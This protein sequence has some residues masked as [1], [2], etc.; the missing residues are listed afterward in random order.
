MR[1]PDKEYLPAGHLPYPNKMRSFLLVLSLT[2]QSCLTKENVEFQREVESPLGCSRSQK[3]RE[4]DE[5]LVTYKGFLAD[6]TVF[7][8][9]EG[10]DPIRFVLGEGRVIAGWEKGLEGTCA[11]EKVVMVIPSSLGYGDRG[12]GGVIPGGATLYFITTLQGI[13]RVT[14]ESSDPEALDSEGKCKDIKKV[15]AK[16]KITIS[17]KVTHQDGSLVD[18]SQDTVEVGSGQLVKGWEL[19]LVGACQGESRQLLLGPSVAWGERGVPGSIPANASVEI[20]VTLSKV[21]RDLVFNFLDQISSGT[22]R[23]G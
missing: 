8:S 16:D 11:G 14:K 21:E 23:R 1:S 18:N 12:A 15:K 19:G 7:D 2:I 17:S 5:L 10:K 22:F 13:V 20:A 9:N 4:G 6:G 3:S